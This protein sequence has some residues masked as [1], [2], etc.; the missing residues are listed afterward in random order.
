MRG[1]S[2]TRVKERPGFQTAAT[3]ETARRVITGAFFCYNRCATT[4]A[5]KNPTTKI[6]AER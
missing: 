1:S 5:K 2:V 4:K 3:A 6:D